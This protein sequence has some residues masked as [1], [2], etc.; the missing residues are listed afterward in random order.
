MLKRLLVSLFLPF[1]FRLAAAVTAVSGMD[2][3]GRRLGD[4]AVAELSGQFDFVERQSVDAIRDETALEQAFAGEKLARK[5]RLTGAELFAAVDTLPSGQRRLTVFESTCGFRLKQRLLSAAD[6]EAVREIG[7]ALAAAAAWNGA[8]ESTRF[9]SVAGVRNNLHYSLDDKALPLIDSLLRRTAELDMVVLER[10]YLI[11]LLREQSLS[12]RWEKK[13]TASEILHF[14]LNPGDSPRRFTIKVYFTDPTGAIVFQQQAEGDDAAG[15]DRLFAAVEE[16]LNSPEATAARFDCR[17]EAARFHREAKLED[18]TALGRLRKEF[19]A[20]ALDDGNPAYLC[21]IRYGE[22]NETYPWLKAVLERIAEKPELLKDLNSNSWARGGLHVLWRDGDRLTPEERRA[23]W[24]FLARH[25]S[26]FLDACVLE[27]QENSEI[28]RLLNRLKNEQ[29]YLYP[30]RTEYITAVVADWESILRSLAANAPEDRR[31]AKWKWLFGILSC[32][33]ADSLF[34]L[35]AAMPQEQRMAWNHAMVSRLN[36]MEIEELK[37]LAAL[38]EADALLCSGGEGA[39]EQAVAAYERYFRLVREN[40]P[41]SPK[42]NTWYRHETAA[43]YPGLPEKLQA[44]AA[45]HQAPPPAEKPSGDR[46]KSVQLWPAGTE[47]ASEAILA[48]ALS[49]DGTEVFFLT[50]DDFDFRVMRLSGKGDAALVGSFP[51][52]PDQ[53][54]GVGSVWRMWT[55]DGRIVLADC[56]HV[57]AGSTGSEVPLRKIGSIP[58]ALNAVWM[59]SGRIFILGNNTLASFDFRGGDRETHFSASQEGKTLALQRKF[60]ECRAFYGCPGAKEGDVVVVFLLRS[61]CEI[62]RFRLSDGND[63]LL[64]R[65][66]MNKDDFTKLTGLAGSFYWP[67]VSVSGGLGIRLF[68]GYDVAKNTLLETGQLSALKLN[69]LFAVYPLPDGRSLI[70]IESARIVRWERADSGR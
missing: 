25:R 54:K 70:V 34:S 41:G 22:V 50:E 35:Q 33:A 10:E 58:F 64:H 9:I 7:A 3:G 4:F 14:E 5:L 11:E 1:G 61:G 26:I 23:H 6:E 19:A 38:L 21:G 12:G 17:S 43:R 46:W 67:V 49:A 27:E 51:R 69:P 63:E 65:L 31:K 8:P 45:E 52:E 13:V 18:T 32:E 68:R 30:D 48:A 37:P 40:E 16:Y 44:M 36:S 66:E 55:G 39:V 53:R 2:D 20:F 62:R 59:Q 29:E 47:P 42:F 60:P 56:R 24:A 15:V 28:L 57:Y